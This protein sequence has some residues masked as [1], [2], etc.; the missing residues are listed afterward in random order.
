[1]DDDDIA[2]KIYW[3]GDVGVRPMSAVRELIGGLTT[4]A[5]QRSGD[6]RPSVKQQGAD[7]RHRP[8]A[9][10][11]TLQDAYC[12]I[13]TDIQEGRLRSGGEDTPQAFARWTRDGLYEDEARSLS[14]IGEMS[15]RGLA[16]HG[17]GRHGWDVC[18][19]P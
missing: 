4:P 13:E 3:V 15:K 8:T 16:S 9:A 5:R 14:R 10:S 1:M 2:T 11:T 18:D 6:I 17:T 19:L 7:C 12:T